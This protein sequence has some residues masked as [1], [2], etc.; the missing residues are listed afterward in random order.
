M[1]GDKELGTASLQGRKRGEKY[2]LHFSSLAP[3]QFP[4]GPMTP[5]ELLSEMS[6]LL[7]P[8]LCIAMMTTQEGLGHQ[9]SALSSSLL[10]SPS[11]WSLGFLDSYLQS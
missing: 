9:K 11:P 6:P 1:L 3:T 10:L 2:Q 5:F 4:R 8:T 7:L